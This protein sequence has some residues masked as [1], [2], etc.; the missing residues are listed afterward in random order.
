[1]PRPRFCGIGN[2]GEYS[3]HRQ[4]HGEHETNARALEPSAPETKQADDR[5][6]PNSTEYDAPLLDLCAFPLESHKKAKGERQREAQFCSP[7]N[8]IHRQNRY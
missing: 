4:T 1:M 8:D 2:S 6:C 7:F 5:I 3:H